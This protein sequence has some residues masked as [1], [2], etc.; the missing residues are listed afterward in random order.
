MTDIGGP[1][2]LHSLLSEMP[3]DFSVP[4]LILQP[5]ESLLLESAIGALQRTAA[6]RLQQIDGRRELR[7][8]H[9]YFAAGGRHHH[10]S[11]TDDG[12][13]IEPSQPGPHW[14][15]STLTEFARLL[16]RQLTVIFLSGRG[17]E[18]EI[19]TACFALEQN[20]CQI[21][22]LQASESTVS[23]LGQ[24]VLRNCPHAAEHSAEQIVGVLVEQQK[25]SPARGPAKAAKA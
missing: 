7:P 6:L 9:V 19:A 3:S 18:Q 10:A 23:D 24:I 21:L 5:P 13:A 11:A 15:G 2:A 25:K 8:R 4:I 16:G 22:V 20:G 1:A 14:V 12:I 17:D